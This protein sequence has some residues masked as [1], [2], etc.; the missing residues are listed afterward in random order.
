VLSLRQYW[1]T[2]SGSEV[3]F[4]WTRGRLAVGIEVKAA[5]TWRREFA[6]PLLGFL[7][8]GMLTAAHGVYTGS[9]VLQ[10]GPLRVWPLP[11]FLRAL[12]SDEVLR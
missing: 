9:A 10:N 5:A 6:Q 2:P 3:D 12:A 8:S 4:I 7:V 1:R 11:A